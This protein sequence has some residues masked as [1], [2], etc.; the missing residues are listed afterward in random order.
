M[1]SEF[2]RKMKEYSH[3]LKTLNVKKRYSELTFIHKLLL[4]L[5]LQIYPPLASSWIYTFTVSAICRCILMTICI[6]MLNKFEI[7]N[8]DVYTFSVFYLVSCFSAVLTT[9]E[10]KNEIRRV[11]FP[12]WDKL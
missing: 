2:Q 11:K 12:S 3:L 6:I 7:F 1:K 8:L 10:V 4:T 5:N 9:Y